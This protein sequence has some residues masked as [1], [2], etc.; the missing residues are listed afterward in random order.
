M[1]TRKRTT[2]KSSLIH[3]NNGDYIHRIASTNLLY[4]SPMSLS[5]SMPT[6]WSNGMFIVRIFRAPKP[7]EFSDAVHAV[8]VFTLGGNK[9]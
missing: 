6:R 3:T 4:N 2:T 8:A 5:L 1:Q 7:I 9:S